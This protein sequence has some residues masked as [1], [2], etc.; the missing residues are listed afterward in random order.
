MKKILLSIVLFTALA[1]IAYGG[2]SKIGIME[3]DE[4][5]IAALNMT[6][7]N[8]TEVHIEKTAPGSGVVSFEE[9]SGLLDISS[10]GFHPTGDPIDI[11]VVARLPFHVSLDRAD[12]TATFRVAFYD[13]NKMLIGLS[14][15]ITVSPAT[16]TTDDYILY[17]TDN[18]VYSVTERDNS[19]AYSLGTKMV[20]V[21]D[22]D[23]GEWYN[24][25]TGGTSA[26]TSP[27]FNAGAGNSTADGTAIWTSLGRS[28]FIHEIPDPF[29]NEIGAAFFK[30][31]IDTVPTNSATLRIKY[32]P[33]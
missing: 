1:C 2:Q 11:K 3:G 27:T 31:F 5:Y 21:A 16:T 25:T 18:T 17:Y 9:N 22:L 14:K 23:T 7:S 33:L 4:A 24:C 32:G 29:A 26:A 20:L 6:D 28:N 12:A 13:L 10:T 19:T 15:K 8:G 30:I